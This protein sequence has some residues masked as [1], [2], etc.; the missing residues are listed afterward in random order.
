MRAREDRLLQEHITTVHIASRGTYESPRIHADLRAHGVA[1]G[2]KRVARLM[3]QAG[4]TGVHR[5]RY[6][7]TTQRATAVQPAPD[8]VKRAFVAR[9]PNRL[10]TADVTAI[11]TRTSFLSVAVILDVFSRRIVGWSMKENLRTDLVLN[12]L[13]MAVRTR[14]PDQGLVHHSDHGSQDTSWTY[15]D[16]CRAFGLVP[17]MGTV[18][19]CYDNAIT[20]SFFATLECELLARTPLAS[21]NHGRRAVFDV[22]ETFYNTGRRHSAC[23]YLSPHTCEQAHRRRAAEPWRSHER[24]YPTTTPA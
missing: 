1:C 2:R 4:L 14:R 8:L 13:E 6:R 20:E 7:G 24:S 23:G 19:D 17:S 11:P 21:P 9:A 10:W 5:R 12:A 16:R 18:G 22:I 15:S 3:G